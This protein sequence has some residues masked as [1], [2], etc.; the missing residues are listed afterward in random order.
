MFSFKRLTAAVVGGMLALALTAASAGA[1]PASP[2]ALEAAQSGVVAAAEAA[3]AHQTDKVGLDRAIEVVTA[4]LKA[5]DKPGK[6]PLHAAN[7]LALVKARKAGE[8]TSPSSLAPGK[9]LEKV[10]EAYKEMRGNA[11]GH[12]KAPGKPVGTPGGPSTP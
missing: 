11:Y 5:D 7:I 8:S 12:D 1:N 10:V 9:A 4:N 2:A 3:R 6:G